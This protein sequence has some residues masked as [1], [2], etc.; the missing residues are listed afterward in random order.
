MFTFLITDDSQNTHELKATSRDIANWEK[1]SRGASMSQLKD[2][3]R[4][5]DLYKIAF[6]TA[7]RTGVFEGNEQSFMDTFDLEIEGDQEDES[8]NPTQ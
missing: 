4:M 3:M 6:F 5:T 2:A 1:T 7:K 8:E